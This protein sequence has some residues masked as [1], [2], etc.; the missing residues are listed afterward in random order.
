MRERCRRTVPFTMP[1][2]VALS[3]WMGVGGW[4]CPNS[5]NAKQKMCLSRMFIKS[6]PSSTSAADVATNLRIAQRV[7]NAPF[8]TM[9]SPFHG[10]QPMKKCPVARLC[11][12]DS[13]RYDASEWMLSTMS[14]A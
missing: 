3:Q 1:V 2:V 11:P 5:Y 13:E 14:D 9:G 7:K 6:S 10:I 8:R 4:G 12:F